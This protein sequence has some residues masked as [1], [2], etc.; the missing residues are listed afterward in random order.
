MHDFL[1]GMHGFGMLT[2]PKVAAA[3]DLSR[4]RRLVDLGGATGHLTIAACELYPEMHGVVFDLQQAVGLARELVAG[5]AASARIEVIAGD[6]FTDSLPAADLYYTG[7]ILH[8]WS[9]DKIERLLARIMERL[10]AGG[11][12]LIGEKLLGEDGVGPLPANMQSLNMLVVTEGRERS[13]SEYRVLLERAGFRQVEGRRTG[14]A[15]DAILA[16]K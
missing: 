15:L 1:M 5:S 3:F 2:S 14:A 11:G 7:R 16:I 13:L 8:D 4:F 9:E 6:F 10:P 12:L